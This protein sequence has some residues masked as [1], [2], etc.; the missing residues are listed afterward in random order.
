MNPTF[1]VR[2]IVS[3][4]FREEDQL[5]LQTAQNILCHLDRHVDT[6][7]DNRDRLIELLHFQRSVQDQVFE[8]VLSLR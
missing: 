1:D 8:R 6:A 4:I 2:Q 3:E 5:F 7:V